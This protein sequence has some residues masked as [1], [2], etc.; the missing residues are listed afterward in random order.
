LNKYSSFKIFSIVFGAFYTAFFVYAWSP[1]RYY[2]IL[3]KFSVEVQ[4]PEA[5]PAILWYGWVAS[6]FVASAA[7]A[8]VVP[9]R[10]AERLWHGYTWV[11]PTI[12]LVVILIHE[13]RWFQ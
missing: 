6:A 11:L 2:P 3:S 12:V 10:V 7:T 13:R 1:F 9:R 8:L 4:G 5:G